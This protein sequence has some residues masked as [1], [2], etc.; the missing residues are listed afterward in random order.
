MAENNDKKYSNRAVFEKNKDKI[1][2]TDTTTHENY[3]EEL[4]FALQD[5]N[6]SFSL[7]LT[8]VLTCLSIAEKEGYVPELPSEW[9]CKIRKI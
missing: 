4:V 1:Q 2:V 3:K 7:G 9:W 8:T 6:H 5:K